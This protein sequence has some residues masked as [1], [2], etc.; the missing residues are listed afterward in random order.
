MKYEK[1]NESKEREKSKQAPISSGR[2][3]LC[4]GTAV[5][6]ACY[7]VDGVRYWVQCFGK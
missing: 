7:E 5:G 1:K 3:S 4:A 2:I 6:I